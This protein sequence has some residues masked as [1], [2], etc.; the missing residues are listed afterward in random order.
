MICKVRDRGAS[1]WDGSVLV[2]SYWFGWTRGLPPALTEFAD[3]ERCR[4]QVSEAGTSIPSGRP[5]PGRF[6]SSRVC[7]ARQR[8][9]SWVMVCVRA[10]ASTVQK[11]CV[12]E[13]HELVLELAMAMASYGSARWRAPEQG[14]REKGARGGGVLT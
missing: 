10:R 3:R 9:C 8:W 14:K 12:Q 7:T 13:Q 4:L 1:N 2:L 6:W 5:A 11:M